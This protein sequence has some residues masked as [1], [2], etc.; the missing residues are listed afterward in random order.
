MSGRAGTSTTCTYTH[1]H[2][3]THTHTFDETKSIYLFSTLV[4]VKTISPG[5]LRYKR[6]FLR[7]SGTTATGAVTISALLLLFVPLDL[8]GL[9][10]EEVEVD[11]E[12]AAAAAAAA[13]WVRAWEEDEE[14]EEEE[15]G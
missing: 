1:T 8:L 7:F 4:S 14:E 6:T 5:V 15:E 9:E 10:E 12:E 2:T 3:H 11:E 13:G